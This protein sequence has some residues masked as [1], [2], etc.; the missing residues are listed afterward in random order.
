MVIVV[1]DD[2][3]VSDMGE[4]MWAVCTRAD[5]ATDYHV[6]TNCWSSALDPL[7]TPEKR[8]K[9]N[10]SNSRVIIDATRPYSWRDEF[11]KVN[12]V[13]KELRAEILKK[14]GDV[15]FE[16]GNG[17]ELAAAMSEAASARR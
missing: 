13:S 15:I 4:L 11:P 10:F 9:K 8:E 17:R 14:W 3:D 16:S 7:L 1:D 2:I 6:M 5:P 12:A